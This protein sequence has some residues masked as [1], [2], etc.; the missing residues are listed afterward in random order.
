M[1]N[2]Y[3]GVGSRKTPPDV[4]SLMTRIATHL[5]SLGKILRSGGAKGADDLF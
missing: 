2:Y 4:L 1:E 3:T 5:D